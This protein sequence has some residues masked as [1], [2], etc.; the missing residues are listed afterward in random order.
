M[1]ERWSCGNNSGIAN[2]TPSGP[3]S[4]LSPTLDPSTCASQPY[5]LYV[6][7]YNVTQQEKEA[8]GQ[9]A[10]KRLWWQGYKGRFGLFEWPTTTP[11]DSGFKHISAFDMSE[12]IALNSAPA[13]EGLLY[14]LNQQYQGNVYVFAH[15]HGNMVVGEAL[16]KAA[17]DNL[18]Q[19]VNTYV[20]CQAAVAVHCYD[21]TQPTPPNYFN[22]WRWVHGVPLDPTGPVTPNIYNNWFATGESAL[23]REPGNFFNV[24]DYCLS[25]KIWETDEAEKPDRWAGFSPPYG[26]SGNIDDNPLQQGDYFYKSL[27]TGHT[28]KG[29]PIYSDIPLNLGTPTDLQDRYEIIAFA[30]QPRCQALGTTANAANFNS[31]DLQQ[32][33]PDDPFYEGNGDKYGPYGTHPWHSGEFNFDTVVQWGFWDALYGPQ[34][35]NLK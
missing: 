20:A 28:D 27:V 26:Y 1:Y 5:I 21:P 23:G 7:G 3:A 19:L 29:H 12:Y 11:G 10:F 34:G 4:I 14:N 6:H 8:D 16:R 9:T 32:L 13:L 30:A 17:L 24:N 22:S 15:S 33:W 2:V 18:G 31:T 35:F 25:H